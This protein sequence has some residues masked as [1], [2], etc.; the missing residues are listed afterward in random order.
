MQLRALFQQ[1]MQRAPAL[2]NVMPTLGKS[3][4]TCTYKLM[5]LVNSYGYGKNGYIQICA[6]YPSLC[7]Y[8]CMY[9]YIER[10]KEKYVERETES[11]R[12]IY[13]CV[14][15]IHI[16]I[17][18]CRIYIYVYIHKCIYCLHVFIGYVCI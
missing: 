11:C 18:T 6:L 14:Y 8:V 16:C 17:H 5:Q 7:T 9:I 10:E 12:A 13:V 2:E 1:S 3:S 4:D 15:V